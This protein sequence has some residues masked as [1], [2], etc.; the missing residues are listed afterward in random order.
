MDRDLKD[1]LYNKQDLINN[2]ASQLIGLEIMEAR[3]KL[4]YWFGRLTKKRKSIHLLGQK[5]FGGLYGISY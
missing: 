5:T 2:T 3:Q 1:I 4:G